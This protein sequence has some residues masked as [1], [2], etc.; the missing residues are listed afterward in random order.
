MIAA[1]KAEV[2][3][4]S[5]ALPMPI[6]PVNQPPK[7]TVLFPHFFDDIT[8]QEKNVSIETPVDYDDSDEDEENNLK[9]NDEM[10]TPKQMP[11]MDKTTI[12]VPKMEVPTMEM[13]KIMV[14]TLEKTTMAQ[15]QMIEVPTTE[16]PII[17]VPKMKVPTIEQMATMAVPTTEMSIAVPNK[18]QIPTVAVPTTALIQTVHTLH[19]ATEEQT[20]IDQ[21]REEEQRE[22]Q[23]EQQQDIVEELQKEG[24]RTETTKTAQLI[25]PKTEEEQNGEE[26]G[27]QIEEP[28]A[29]EAAEQSD[30]QL[31]QQAVPATQQSIEEETAQVREEQQHEQK[32]QTETITLVKALEKTPKA[33]A[34]E[35]TAE[36]AK[37]ELEQIQA[38]RPP[39]EEATKVPIN[40]SMH[41]SSAEKEVPSPSGDHAAHPPSATPPFRAVCPPSATPPMHTKSK[42]FRA[43]R[44]FSIP[45]Q[46]Q[47]KKGLQKIQSQEDPPADDVRLG[48]TVLRGTDLRHHPLRQTLP[49]EEPRHKEAIFP[50]ALSPP[51]NKPKIGTIGRTEE[52]A[53]IVEEVQESDNGEEEKH[54]KRIYLDYTR[55]NRI[56]R[57]VR[58]EHKNSKELIKDECVQS[59]D[60][61]RRQFLCCVK[62]WCDLGGECGMAKFCLPSCEMTKLAHLSELSPEGM[63][64]IDLLYD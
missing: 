41:Q 21:R 9:R 48:L 42:H 55:Q 35:K 57:P 40:G 37:S 30:G 51:P 7:Q 23:E 58:V 63:P 36:E 16:M 39:S 1:E 44:P 11:T 60:C 22:E 3:N 59:R 62:R 14:P 15:R 50:T 29:E 46:K 4:F 12:V 2:P 33:L 28:N 24:K 32:A 34:Q 20:Q 56:S 17:A 47:Q 64:R 61:G 53:Q 5:M 54:G 31:G 8:A 19:F 25:V 52:M 38:V 45:Q 10:A 18:A 49:W 26:E 43:L 27:Q 13:P 6:V